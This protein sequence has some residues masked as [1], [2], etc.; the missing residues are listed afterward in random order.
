MYLRTSFSLAFRVS[1]SI[2]E[3]GEVDARDVEVWYDQLTFYGP[4]SDRQ[5]NVCR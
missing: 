1:A 2:M 3:R 5:T 4:F